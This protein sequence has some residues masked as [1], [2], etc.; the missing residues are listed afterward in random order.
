MKHIDSV[1]RAVQEDASRVAEQAAAANPELGKPAN[2]TGAEGEANDNGKKP[3]DADARKE[4]LAAQRDRRKAAEFLKMAKGKAEKAEA[5]D[6]ARALAENGEDPTEILK[7][8]GLNPI[9]YY[10]DLTKYALSDKAKTVEDPVQK[11]LREH[12]ER[13]DKYAKDLEVQATSIRE[14]EEVAAHNQVITEKVVPLLRDNADQYEALLT[15]YGANAAVEVYKTVWE[16]YQQTGKARSFTEVA[17]EMEAYW[18]ETIDKGIQ[19]ASRL[20][21]F[22]NR[23]AQN[24]NGTRETAV[25]RAETPKRVVTLSNRPSVAASPTTAPV[26]KRVLTRD[27]RVAEILKRFP[28]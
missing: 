6:K 8:A 24:D 10:Q 26:R 25:A 1:G 13:L 14:K 7:A 27:E 11:E 23:F 22:Q 12:K 28:D 15:E 9:K 2:D 3:T 5:F 17:N 16:I 20:K 18:T 21:K 19:A 4:Y